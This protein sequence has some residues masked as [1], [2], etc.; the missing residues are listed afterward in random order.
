MTRHQTYGTIFLV[1]LTFGF[2]IDTAL[3]TALQSQGNPLRAWGRLVSWL[4]RSDWMAV[5]LLI[6][7]F[8]AAI[9]ARSSDDVLGR[10]I[11][12]LL[13]K[14]AIVLFF[15]ILLSGICVQILKH[16]FG[17]ARPVLFQDLGAF[18]FQPLAFDMRLNSFPSGH[19]TTMGAIAMVGA[20]VAPR[21]STYVFG[22]AAIV[23]LAR[24]LDGAH[25]ASDVIA[26]LAL[27]ATFSYLFMNALIDAGEIPRPG[28]TEWSA[29]GRK[30][31]AWYKVLVRP[32]TPQPV[33]VLLLRLMIGL[34][35]LCFVSLVIFISNPSIDIAVSNAFF[36]PQTGF[37]LNKSSFLAFLQEL[38]LQ[39][40]FLVL[41]SALMLWYLS[42]RLRENT[43]VHPSIWAFIVT[44]LVVGPGLVANSLLKTHWGRARPANIETFGGDA[45]YTLPFQFANEC[46]MNCSFVSG[47]GSVIAML[48][49]VFMALAW[50]RISKAPLPIMT[51]VCSIAAFGIAMRV[52]KGRHFLSDSVFAILIMALVAMVLYRAFDVSRHRKTLTQ[53]NFASD[54]QLGYAYVFAPFSTSRSLIQDLWRAVLA[55]RYVGQ[56]TKNILTAAA[57]SLPD[58]KRAARRLVNL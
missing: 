35:F 37:W 3:I 42:L 56:V 43:K 39:T 1:V 36:D 50:T 53:A 22:F 23:G 2:L 10:R 13:L 32:Q 15:A 31:A 21:F 30:V 41:I 9:A 5:V 4:G 7:A 45:A 54:C 57:R 47:E 25:Y 20:M 46:A 27:G 12:K 14:L 48:L 8:A 58:P 24:I 11:A 49:F 29:V 40:A 17:R 16:L 33:D 51:T 44:A 52:I 55:I 6:W 28:R 34:L 38:Y 26:G 18:S 19:A